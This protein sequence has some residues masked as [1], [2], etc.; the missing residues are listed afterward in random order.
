MWIERPLEQEIELKTLRQQLCKSQKIWA[1]LKKNDRQ[2]ENLKKH[3]R[4]CWMLSE[5]VWAI[6]QV[7]MM[8]RMGKTRMMKRTQSLASWAKIMNLAG[9]WAQSPKRY[10]T[11]WRV[12][13]RTRWGMTNWRNRD[14]GT[15]QTTLG[16]EKWCMEQPNWWLWP[17][18]SLK[19]TRLLP[20]HHR[21]LWQVYADSWYCPWTI[22][23]V[24]RDFSTRKL[25]HEARFRGTTVIHWHSISLAWCSSQFVADWECEGCWTRKDW[26]PHI[27]SLANYDVEIGFGWRH[28]DGSCVTGDIDSQI[29]NID[30][31]ALVKVIC[32]PI[33]LSVSLFWIS[34]TKLWDMLIRQCVCK[35]HMGHPTVPDAKSSWSTT[36][37]GYIILPVKV[38]LE[39]KT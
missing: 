36:N 28:G 17:M 2:P 33:L 27:A 20:H 1:T 31:V 12:F 16:R 9:W 18:G 13:G 11:T 15:R 6:L 3:L 5:T 39:S 34:V 22:T 14:G 4:R 37:E 8:R 24:T 29:V 35:G 26:P 23:D 21:R 32:V 30:D 7:L 38:E 19:S 25:S 10:S